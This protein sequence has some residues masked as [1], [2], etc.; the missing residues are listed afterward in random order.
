MKVLQNTN[1]VF[2]ASAILGF[3]FPQLS[4]VTRSFVIP[5]LAI[6]M[7][8][9]LANLD[10]SRISKDSLPDVVTNFLIN[11]VVLTGIILTLAY[12]LID[13]EAIRLGFVVMACVPPAIAIVPFTYLLR[14][15]VEEALI[16]NTSIY[17]V[18]I[19]LMPALMTLLTKN[20]TNPVEILKILVVLILIP[21]AVSRFLKLNDTRVVVNVGLGVVIYTVVGLNRNLLF[22]SDLILLIALICFVRTFVSGTAILLIAKS[23]MKLESAIVKALFGSYK[24][25]GFSATV[26]LVLFGEKASLPSAI[27][28]LLEVFLFLYYSYVLRVIRSN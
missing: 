8:F 21:L 3:V 18:S 11:Y 16:S 20:Q 22:Q 5:S 19:F 15:D 2:A 1:L 12:A 23:R 28:I 10:F 9:S 4:A 25:L 6:V 14:G 17:L 13:D 7:C 26:A 24:N 27:C